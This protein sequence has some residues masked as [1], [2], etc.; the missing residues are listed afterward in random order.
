M[1]CNFYIL[2]AVSSSSFRDEE[3]R[4]DAAG[5]NNNT[6]D[7]ELLQYQYAI[8]FIS[9]TALL[10]KWVGGDRTWYGI[11]TQISYLRIS[12]TMSV[13]TLLGTYNL[14]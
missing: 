2:K 5:V 7:G 8:V 4:D 6:I 11:C 13:I 10:C 14:T 1:L 3:I 12:G 9:P